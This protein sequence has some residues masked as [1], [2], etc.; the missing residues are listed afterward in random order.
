MPSYTTQQIAQR[1]GGTLAGPAD[2][3]L[4]GVEG[5][6]TAGPDHLTFIRDA[7]N[8]SRWD[9]C[10]AG[11][12]LVSKGVEIAADPSRALIH[13][14]DAD[15]ALATVLE[16]FAPPP[17]RPAAGVHPSAVVDPSAVLGAGVAVGPHA[18]IGPRVRIG[19][20]TVIHAN[21]TILDETV[22]G[23]ECEI[24]PGVV[25][26]DR[27][28]AGDR[29]IIHPNT[30]IGSD[31]FGYR[32]TPRG[33]V[34]IPHIG[35]VV[36]G[37]DVELGA[38]VCIDRGKFSDTTIGDGTKID[39]QVHI[40]HNCRI[41]RSCLI[42]GQVG[43]AGSVTMGDGVMVG[44]ATIFRDHITVGSGA[45]I[46]GGSAVLG[47]V[48]DGASWGGSPARDIREAFKE[49]A[50]LRRLPDLLKQLKQVKK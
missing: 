8:A 23:R 25:F 33:A 45:S 46:A 16:M 20:S 43:F 32:A 38:G 27:C 29:V 6:D 50:A 36:I 24:F 10:K 14:P 13:I 9:A 30:T 48:P 2:K 18:F 12:A 28:A 34:K 3:T 40:A 5:L 1:V 39:N 17:A 21:V 42:A 7:A 41:G 31:G 35:R 37:S 19:D 22:L 11:G 44:G 47:D 26:R 15:L 49:Y 4:H